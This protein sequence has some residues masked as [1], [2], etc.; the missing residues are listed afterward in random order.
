MEYIIGTT[1]VSRLELFGAHVRLSLCG[2]FGTAL[3]TATDV[4]L[5]VAH[6]FPIGAHLDVLVRTPRAD[7]DEL[8]AT[9]ADPPGP[10]GEVWCS[11]WERQGPHPPT[12]P[13][14]VRVPEPSEQLVAAELPA[15][16]ESQEVGVDLPPPRIRKRGPPELR[17]DHDPTLAAMGADES[18]LETDPAQLADRRAKLTRLVGLVGS[19]SRAARLLCARVQSVHGA[20]SGQR[21]ALLGQQRFVRQLDLLLREV[22]RDAA[23]R[24]AWVHKRSSQALRQMG[25]EWVATVSRLSK[26]RIEDWRRS[27]DVQR[28]HHQT[29]PRVTA[30][31]LAGA[32]ARAQVIEDMRSAGVAEPLIEGMDERIGAEAYTEQQAE[33]A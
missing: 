29:D 16:S 1:L 27:P 7:T 13:I 23:T 15:S 4:P 12:T 21:H 28:Q 20:L 22:P 18:A 24:H 8:E 5:D 31:A 26:A 19:H 17:P 6:Q 9:Q 3:D 10:S 33:G 2:G 30:E 25:L 14:V 32:W 11:E